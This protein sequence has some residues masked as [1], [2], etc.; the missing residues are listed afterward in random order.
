MNTKLLKAAEAAEILKVSK[1]KV[2]T[3]MRRGELP[4]VRIGTLVRVRY[5]DLVQYMNEKAKQTAL[6]TEKQTPPHWTPSVNMGDSW[7]GAPK[8]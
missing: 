4:C 8:T 2:Y 5:A 3:L 1:E 7:L 6:Y